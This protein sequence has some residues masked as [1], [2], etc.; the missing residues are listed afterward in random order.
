MDYRECSLEE[1]QLRMLEMLCEIDRICKKY[2][3]K[4]WLD[5]G[6]LLGAIRHKGFIPWDDDI[7]IGMIREDYRK[8]KSVVKDELDQNYFCQSPLTDSYS[9]APW[10]KIRDNNSRIGEEKREKGHSGLF[11]DI[12]PYDD[13]NDYNNAK[14]KPIYNIINL[15]W[16]SELPYKKG[17]KNIPRN[18]SLFSLKLIYKILPYKMFIKKTFYMADKAK[19]MNSE[20]IDYGIES[21]WNMRLK[22]SDVFPLKSTEFAG[23]KFMI[24][25][26]YENVLKCLYGEW[27]V[28]PPKEKRIPTHSAKIYI[29]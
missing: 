5:A 16:K 22:K 27:N 20:Y 25:N 10:I 13:Y 11:I 15:K 1:A 6:T 17:I 28:L 23:Y 24:P 12:L 7:D 29:R 19:N 8:F 14:K 18:I 21:P 26:K 2:D 3:I 9:E 4:Y